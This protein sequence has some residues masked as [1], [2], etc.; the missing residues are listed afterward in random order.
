MVEISI[1]P[2]DDPDRDWIGKLMTI[3]WNDPSVVVHGER[4]YPAEL[5]GYLAFQ[6]S[7]PC[8]L[9]TYSIQGS[10]CEVVTLDALLPAHGIGSRLIETLKDKA[11][12]SGCTRLWLITT[13]D[14]TDALTFYQKRGFRMA[15]LHAS[16]VE[17][18][19]QLKPQIPLV[20]ENGIPIRDEIELEMD[21]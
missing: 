3:R 20:A 15:A 14:N 10:D 2:V 5:P 12:K 6:G 1:R 19:R 17:L 8:G 21:L 13:N 11:K 9:I 4:F 18:A 16:A 7:E